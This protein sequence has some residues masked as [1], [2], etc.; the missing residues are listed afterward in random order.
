MPG[1]R[2]SGQSLQARS[3]K[4]PTAILRY[5]VP[6]AAYQRQKRC[7]VAPSYCT[8]PRIGPVAVTADTFVGFAGQRR[9]LA[10][11]AL[12][13]SDI[14]QVCH[15]AKQLLWFNGGFGARKVGKPI[16]FYGNI[17]V[18]W[19]A[20]RVPRPKPQR[21]RPQR[22]ARTQICGKRTGEKYSITL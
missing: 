6:S 14:V 15:F 18:R 3:R 2:R 8:I 13:E 9:R 21:E 10:C 19:G 20:L 7:R 12:G 16:D 4:C 1:I 17:T 22:S 11:A 5:Q